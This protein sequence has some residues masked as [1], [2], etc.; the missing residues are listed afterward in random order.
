MQKDK[1]KNFIK[2]NA[3]FIYSYINSEVLQGIG[4]INANYFVK[5]IEDIFVKKTDL[6]LNFDNTNLL[7]YFILSLIEKKG[8]I[9]YTSLRQESI[10]FA[11]INEEAGVYYNYAKFILCDEFLTINLMQTKIGG[12][13]IDNDIVKFSKK[14]S[15][16]S[17]GLEE[18]IV[19]NKEIKNN[20]T[21]NHNAINII[22]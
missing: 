1:A 3:Y 4:Y 20:Y 11:A 18:F 17:N 6:E 19:H 10:N 15:I 13:P 21:K 2:E 7:P 8:K 22:F 5:T 14:I 16:V 9:D 12:M